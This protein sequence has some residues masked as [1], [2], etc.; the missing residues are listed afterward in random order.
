MISRISVIERASAI[1]IKV[2]FLCTSGV[3]VWEH[4]ANAVFRLPKAGAREQP[5]LAACGHAIG[6][7]GSQSRN[8]CYLEDMRRQPVWSGPP[9]HQSS[10]TGT[11]QRPMPTD[12]RKW[13]LA[14]LDTLSSKIRHVDDRAVAIEG[15]RILDIHLRKL[16]EAL[17]DHMQ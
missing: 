17:G 12:D 16:L 5:L 6:S 11:P 7:H 15:H 9:Q 3:M 13:P 8:S 14:C 4:S 10:T 2:S 1:K